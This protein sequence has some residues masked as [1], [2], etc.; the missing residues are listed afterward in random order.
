MEIPTFNLW[1]VDFA[2][3]EFNKNQAM[4]LVQKYLTELEVITKSQIKGH[5][6]RLFADEIAIDTKKIPEFNDK[7]VYQLKISLRFAQLPPYLDFW[8]MTIC[9][10]KETDFPVLVS[11]SEEVANSASYDMLILCPDIKNFS[12]LMENV[13]TSQAVH[14]VINVM[15]KIKLYT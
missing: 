7:K 13:A 14:L 3:D 15:D 4:L 5:C 11:L 2:Q 9:H 8:L 6:T 1:K 10:M 12:R